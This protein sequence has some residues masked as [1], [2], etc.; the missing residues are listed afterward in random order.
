MF[1]GAVI[2]DLPPGLSLSCSH[3]AQHVLPKTD[4]ALTLLRQLRPRAVTT[5]W[6]EGLCSV[7]TLYRTLSQ[8]SSL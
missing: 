6:K 4:L 7:P 8:K 2:L 5:V 3:E 1:P